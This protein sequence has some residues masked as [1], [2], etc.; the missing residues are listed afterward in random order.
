MIARPYLGVCRDGL[1]NGQPLHQVPA[2][3]LVLLPLRGRLAAR[4]LQ[5]RSHQLDLL[6]PGPQVYAQAC[7]LHTH[8]TVRE[9]W[10]AARQAGAAV[11]AHQ[12]MQLVWVLTMLAV[13]C[14]CDAGHLSA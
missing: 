9:H 11:F 3:L 13:T 12:R 4:T 10:N 5:L 6:L 2:G 14:T 8:A 1:G 7:H